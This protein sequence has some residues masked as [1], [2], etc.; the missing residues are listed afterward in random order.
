MHTSVNH[1]IFERKLRCSK[2]SM[3]VWAMV[4]HHK[5]THTHTYTSLLL[6]L[7]F[8]LNNIRQQQQQ[9]QLLLAVMIV[10]EIKSQDFRNMC[11][12]ASHSGFLFFFFFY[13]YSWLNDDRVV[14]ALFFFR[15]WF[16]TNMLW[17]GCFFYCLL[18][19]YYWGD[20]MYLSIFT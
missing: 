6:L 9:Q 18:C 16:V 10:L 5:K 4:T 8:S 12:S 7:F 19:S 1:Q 13:Y 20:D 3:P 14:A 2:S 11:I 17:K 15:D